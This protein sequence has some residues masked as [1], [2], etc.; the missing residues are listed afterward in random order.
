M[1]NIYFYAL[2]LVLS[3]SICRADD[4]RFNT[5][6]DQEKQDG[7]QFLFNGKDLTGWKG[8]KKDA[9]P[10]GWAA[11]DGALMR[12]KKAGDILTTDKYGD[13]DLQLEWKI[14]EGGNSGIFIRAT[15]DVKK[16][17][18][19]AIEMQIL[20]NEGARKKKKDPN[21]LKAKNCAGA[22]Y[23]LYPTDMNAVRKA[24]EWNTVRI[25]A[26]GEHIQFWLNDVKT[27]DFIIGSEDWNTHMAASKYKR[28]PDFAKNKS[29]H[30]ALQ[31]H[32]CT[33]WYRN[34]K[35]KEL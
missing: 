22:C 26:R 8:W 32:G 14:E 28:H 35:I 23:D 20:D 6:T 5:L 13:F 34:I 2:S 9:A 15:E 4:A 19:K 31:D 7:W 3:I 10:D 30:I 18:H 21:N 16:I 24:G 29:G 33:V 1:R 17:W 12:S 27:A 11:K 25:L